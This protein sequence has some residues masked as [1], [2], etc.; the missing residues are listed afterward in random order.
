MNG[1]TPCALCGLPAARSKIRLN[2]DGVS[3]PFCCPGCLNVYQILV[4]NPGGPPL[5]FKETELYRTCLALGIIAIPEG[6]APDNSE[7]RPRQKQAAPEAAKTDWAKLGQDLTLKIEGMWCTACSWVID[8]ALRRS[9]GVVDVE[10]SF[11]ADLLR[12]KYLPHLTNPE[13]IQ[14]RIRRLG[15]GTSP[16]SSESGDSL[17]DRGLFLRL[18]VSAILTANIMMISFALY[19]GL[20][21]D[22]G[23]DALMILS[24]PLLA[25]ATPVLF[26]GGLPIIRRGISGIRH[27]AMS[28][29]TLI[30]VGSISAYVYSIMEMR[31]G[32]AHLYFDTAAMLVTVS[33][34]GK[35]IETRA[36]EG[37]S[38]AILD[39]YGLTDGKARLAN[40]GRETWVASG[41][42]EVG[43]QFV[44]S[45][46]ERTPLDGVVV[47]GRGHVDESVL[48]GEPRPVMKSAGETLL[49]GSL[50]LDGE[51]EVRALRTAEE[52]SIGRLIEMIRKVLAGKSP[53]E[54]LADRITRWFVPAVLVLGVSLFFILRATEFSSHEALMRAL[55]VLV[56]TCPCALAVATPLAKIA[57]ITAGRT[58]GILIRDHQGFERVA[59]VDTVVFDK[60]G[61]L[62][63]GTFAL[64]GIVTLGVSEVKAL[65]RVASIQAD[66]DHFLAREIRRAAE[67]RQITLERMLSHQYL[68]GMGVRGTLEEGEVAAGNR[69]LMGSLGLRIPQGLEASARAIEEHGGTTVFF[70]WE[71]EVQGIL[72]FGDVIKESGRKAV[73]ALQAMGVS[74][75]LASGD[76]RETTEAVAGQLGIT[77]C[78]GGALPREKMEL[79]ERLQSEGHVVGFAGDGINDAPALTQADAGFA[80]GT[81]VHAFHDAGHVG[82]LGNDPRKVLTAIR[83]SARVSRTIR[84]NLFFALFY[85]ILA[86]PFAATGLL[87]PLIAV[88]A[89][90]LS[91]LTVIGN[92]LKLTK[93]EP[94]RET[95]A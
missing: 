74:V 9:R 60:T 70:S 64:T 73:T 1:D 26:Y 12:V 61:T 57:S 27:G 35:F 76:S 80:F 20:F 50:L 81:A 49:A 38:K 5:D 33:L 30:G 13:E 36:K 15:Y 77:R 71:C 4:N 92:T 79:V 8:H 75:W 45:A 55:T 25:L 6:A 51:L 72:G 54:V 32:T 82:L 87:N 83:F 91:S 68:E 29:D 3:H 7:L 47:S 86:I 59:K 46:R 48:T 78:M 43:M 56:I 94:I 11:L 90:F 95:L 24:I 39:L 21:Q 23:E 84:Q 66:C 69:A 67:A 89:M 37:I 41:A 14:R 18:G 16:F 53:S 31:S 44:V 34:L 42:V 88:V 17:R 40:R 22:L 19:F 62:T 58:M 10:V 93:Q 63:E 85:N 28:M 52:S 2:L 65:R